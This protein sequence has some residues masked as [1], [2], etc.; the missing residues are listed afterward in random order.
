MNRTPRHTNEE[1]RR[2]ARAAENFDP[3]DAEIRDL[4]ELRAVANAADAVKDA[5][6][7]LQDAVA[8]AYL[9]G[10]YSWNRIADALGVSRQA[11]RQRYADW[12]Q[13]K[14]DDPEFQER[15]QQLLADER[16]AFQ[17]AEE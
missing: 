2:A 5:N 10:G 16:S 3:A 14:R 11:A 1:I 17:P 7:R 12:V 8:V 6:A 9:L 13:S 15:L 4:D